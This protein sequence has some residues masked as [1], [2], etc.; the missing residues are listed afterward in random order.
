MSD[1][2]PTDTPKKQPA[3]AVYERHADW[4]CPLCLTKNR[5]RA[6]NGDA[7]KTGKCTHCHSI[8]RLAY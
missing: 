2:P 3:H 7:P 8:A 1:K 6:I 5:T 4:F